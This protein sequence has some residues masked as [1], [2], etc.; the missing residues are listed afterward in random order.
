MRGNKNFLFSVL[1]YTHREQFNRVQKDGKFIGSGYTKA[2]Y[3]EFTNA[4]FTQEKPVTNET[5]HLGI[6]GPFIRA[7]VGD[8]IE[9][10]FKNMASRPYSIH[11]Q[12]L[13]YNKT[14]EGMLYSDG[15]SGNSGD[16]VQPG[17]TFVYRWEVPATSGPAPNEANCKNMMYHSAVNPVKDIYSGLV[18]PIV[19]CR[20]NILDFNGK[21]TDSVEKEFA[22]LFQA[23]DEKSSW[24]INKNIQENCPTA[25]TSTP[26]FEESNKY[27][28]INGL[29]YDNIKGLTAKLG[30][31]IAWYIMGL[32]ENKDIHTAHLHGQTYTYRSGS[33]QEG[34]VVEVFPG[35]Y[36]TVE[37]FASNPGTWLL[38]CHVGEHTRDGM[39]ATYTISS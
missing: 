31:N 19:I 14:N 11:A 21:R 12:G 35:T 25:D 5:M 26:E 38:H 16:I 30:D 6:I 17:N 15:F 10:V 27:D 36:E 20:K 13:R 18:G 1:S 28:S 24:Y 9:V 22:L 37:M 33:T 4:T 8:I 23:F 7:E 3:R 34:D 32:G 39:V 2:L 29:I